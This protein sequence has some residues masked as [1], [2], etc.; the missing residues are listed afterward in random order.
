MGDCSV[1]DVSEALPTCDYSSYV[2]ASTLSPSVRSEYRFFFFWFSLYCCALTAPV[3]SFSLTLLLIHPQYSLCSLPNAEEEFRECALLLLMKSTCYGAFFFIYL[4][5]PSR[6]L[7]SCYQTNWSLLA[8]ACGNLCRQVK[9]KRIAIVFV[10]GVTSECSG[11]FTA[12]I[13][14][15]FFSNCFHWI[16]WKLMNCTAV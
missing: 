4:Y 11:C 10:Y 7:L 8:G 9:K 16:L 5:L 12:T 2:T 13:Q 15:M 6:T 1:P 3:D 14:W